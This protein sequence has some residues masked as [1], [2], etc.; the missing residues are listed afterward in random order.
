M[1][2]LGNIRKRSG[3]AV[4]FVGVAI[5][6]FVL[7]D[8]GNSTWRNPTSLG[9]VAGDKISYIDFEKKVEENLE[10][11]KQSLQKENLT[12][13]E[14]YSVRQ[15]TWNQLVNQIIME[16]AF[17]ETGLTISQDEL[18]DL[19]QGPNPHKY[20]LQN[21][22]NPQTGQL[23]RELLMNF[24]QTL[25]QRE[26]ELQKQMENLIEAIRQDRLNTKFNV[27]IGKAYYMPS[28]LVLKDYQLK[29]VKASFNF[30]AQ[31]FT[32]VPDSLV[33]V[34]DKDLI[35]YYDKH[36][37]NYEQE[38]SRDIDY[39]VFDVLPSAEDY[40]A[41]ENEIKRLYEEMATSN[42]IVNFVNFN[43][44]EKYDS[45]FKKKGTLPVQIDSI[46]FNSPV[47]TMVG[48]WMENNTYYIA[49]LLDVQERPD[50]LKASHILISYQ[51][52]YGAGQD[53]KR[54]KEQANKLADS[55]TS[56][57][58]TNKKKFSELA[59]QFSNDPSVQ[60]NSG[61]L[62]W[63]AD[64]QM[65]YPFNQ[66]VLKTKVG[67]ITLVESAFGFHVIEVTGK[68]T[69]IKKVRVAILK[70]AINP[71]T[72]TQ[73]K[74]YAQ[75][76]TFASQCKTK[77]DF[78]KKVQEMGL[79]KRTKDYLSA[80]DM[81]LPGIDDSREIV[82]W[83]FSKEVE[84]G[85]ISDVKDF[86]N[87]FVVAILKKIHPKGIAPLEDIKESIEASVKKEKKVKMLANKMKETGAKDLYEL[88][89][90]LN[91]KVDTASDVTFYTY[92]IPG[93]GREPNLIGTVFS[94]NPNEVSD[95]IEGLNNA[96][97]AKVKTFTDAPA[98]SDFTIE[99]KQL[100]NNFFARSSS[101]T[102]KALE[103]LADVEDNRVLFY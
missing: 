40:A 86:G 17:E 25:D 71:S 69:P 49:K 67:D 78:E 59:V 43:S 57:L 93:I 23:D 94:L 22:Q 77:E 12:S 41:A 61:D 13:E 76:S 84:V 79:N 2:V 85:A 64:G 5:L 60:Q 51:G 89:S 100:E 74:V 99:R 68:T 27:L 46:M 7:G 90:K 101:G 73:Q 39:V 18:T 62:G 48:P 26:P 92:N 29:N 20:I 1:A 56:V 3:L 54:T 38:E 98:K 31:S 58:K 81:G 95:P 96:F 88:A 8:I 9:V 16:K 6:A 80:M 50:S 10:Y 87:K 24:L 66:A 82:R 47:G 103:K 32:L 34:S 44:D 30:V 14:I 15:N 45:T 35:A 53:I 4:I 28:A 36:K 72:K 55:L 70:K 37:Q 63:F 21:F 75:A 33:K 97:V 102:Y 91:A 52:A 83:A 65:I 11:T 42:D 19:I